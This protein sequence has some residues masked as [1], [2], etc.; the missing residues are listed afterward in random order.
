VVL[1]LDPAAFL[2]PFIQDWPLPSTSG[3]TLLVQRR[4][5]RVVYL[6][7]LRYRKD[8]A[9]KLT[10]S[11]SAPDLPAAMAA[12]GIVAGVD[13]R[14]VPVL[15]ALEPVPGTEWFVVSKVDT[16]EVLDPIRT[17]GWLTAGF[18]LLV[19]ALAGA[20]T[21]LLWRP[22]VAGFGRDPRERGALPSAGRTRSHGDLRE[23]R[24]P[25][26][27]RERGVSAIVRRHVA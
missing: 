15:A 5:D 20:G 27:A 6:N 7:Q 10:V 25:H 4:G 2:Y 3:E 24:G 11:A 9:L 23:P 17:R 1:H 21:L 14:G 8:S 19:V 26:R 13:Y 12:R 18:T 22:R 16:S